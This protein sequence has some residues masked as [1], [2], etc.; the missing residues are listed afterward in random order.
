LLL[1]AQLNVDADHLAD[2]YLEAYPNPRPFVTLLPINQ[3]QLQSAEVRLFEVGTVR[4]NVSLLLAVVASKL[5]VIAWCTASRNRTSRTVKFLGHADA[6]E[7]RRSAAE[8]Q[9]RE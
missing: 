4:T 2:E 6:V 3:A 5:A 8:R 1:V 7:H 9:N